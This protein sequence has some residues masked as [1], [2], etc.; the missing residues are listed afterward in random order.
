MTQQ[1]C[2]FV[3]EVD[4]D[5]N[6][7]TLEPRHYRLHDLLESH[8][9]RSKKRLSRKTIL[10][11][12]DEY[13]GYGEEHKQYPNRTLNDM[14]CVRQLTDDINVITRCT[15]FQLVYTGGRYATSN[16]E[17]DEYQKKEKIRI[18]KEMDKWWIQE[19]KRLSDGQ[20]R[21]V[22]NTEQD[23]IQAFIRKENI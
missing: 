22:F 20:T 7:I 12:L 6:M 8:S 11:L 23:M 14:T 2:L 21:I 13:Y 18:L 16:E 15:T 17:M 3:D 9:R 1:T 10:V 5:G 4:I 19:R